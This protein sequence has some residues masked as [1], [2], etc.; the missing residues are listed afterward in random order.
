M[1]S[2]LVHKIPF[3]A[4]SSFAL[5]GKLKAEKASKKVMS[6]V[7]THV[8]EKDNEFSVIQRELNAAKDEVLATTKAA[9][10]KISVIER[11]LNAKLNAAN[12]KLDA[13]KDELAAVKDEFNDFKMKGASFQDIFRIAFMRSFQGM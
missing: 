13:A 11:E 1:F 7:Q 2:K 10:D 12:D 8:A 4:S 3:R 6:L 9:N 5:L